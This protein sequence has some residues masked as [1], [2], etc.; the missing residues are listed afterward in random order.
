MS[1]DAKYWTEAWATGGGRNGSAGLASGMLTVT[2]TSPTELGGSGKGHNPEELFATGYA[3]CYLGAMRFAAQ[4]EKLGSVPDDAKVTA[5]VGI[6]PRSD[7]G[8]G[9]KVKLAVSMPGVER[10]VAEKIAERGH[11]ICPYSNATK[12]NIDVETEIV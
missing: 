11:F 12:G 8:F 7:G 10:D 5:H 3:A 4:S 6:G 2:M 1:V 9:L